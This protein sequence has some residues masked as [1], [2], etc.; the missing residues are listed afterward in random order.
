EEHGKV[1]WQAWSADLFVRAK[2]EH[3]FVLLHLAAVWCHWCH[4]MEQTT[5]ADDAVVAA[6]AANYIPVRVDQD[7]RPDLLLRYEDWGWPAPIVFGPDGTEIVKL[8]GYREPKRFNHILAAIVS[9][10]SPVDYG[11]IPPD[12]PGGQ[13]SALSPEQRRKLTAF[14]T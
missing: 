13:R 10:P 1:P 12:E 8:R 14:L 11:T 3:R 7:A 9:D 4:V 6:I 2:A 5:Y